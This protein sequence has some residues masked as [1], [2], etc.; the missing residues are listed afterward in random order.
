[1]KFFTTGGAK[2]RTAL[3]IASLK[4]AKMAVI[5]IVCLELRNMQTDCVKN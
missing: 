2:A 1:V 3:P 5:R 4:L